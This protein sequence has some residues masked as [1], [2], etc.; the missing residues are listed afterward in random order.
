MAC[1][2]VPMSLAIVTTIFRKKIPETLKIQI[3]K[4]RP[5][6]LHKPKK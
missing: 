4:Y 1:F 3:K 5:Q 6:L 2:I